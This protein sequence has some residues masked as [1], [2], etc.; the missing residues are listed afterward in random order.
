[1]TEKT[2]K[3]S[4][5]LLIDDKPETE[6]PLNPLFVRHIR[7]SW[8]ITNQEERTFFYVRTMLGFTP[9]M[10]DQISIPDY[11]RLVEKVYD[12]LG[13]GGAPSGSD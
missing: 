11:E 2:F 1:M 12:F 7:D 13:L 6:V 3:F 4:A 5:E 9:D 8:H 10:M